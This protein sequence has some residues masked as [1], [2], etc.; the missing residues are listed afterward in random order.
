ME[1]AN[2]SSIINSLGGGQHEHLG[3]VLPD[4][5]WN[6]ITG[7]TYNKPSYPV[8]FKLDENTQPHEAFIMRELYNEKLDLFRENAAIESA[9]KSQIVAVI[10]PLYLKE[11]K[12]STTETI[13]HTISQILTQIFQ[14]YWAS[15][16]SPVMRRRRKSTEFCI[17]YK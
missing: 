1:Q 7:Y 4:A 2:A 16:I 5:E 14:Q 8:N 6:R 12:N 11:L 15:S 3:L 9:I 13:K 17:Q 10:E